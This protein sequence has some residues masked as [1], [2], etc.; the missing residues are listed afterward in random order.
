[1]LSLI[2]KPTPKASDIKFLRTYSDSSIADIKRAAENGCSIR[3]FHIFEGDWQSERYVIARLYREFANNDLVPFLI[4]EDGK[5]FET[6]H[7]LKHR[8]EELRE[9]ELQTQRDTDLEMGHI[10]T[11]KE[12]KPHDDEWF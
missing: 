3:D 1:M 5:V 8:L 4:C 2:P 10:R 7:S 6:P 9:T 12:F 11:P